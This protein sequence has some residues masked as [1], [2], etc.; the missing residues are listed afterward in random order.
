MPKKRS[1][2]MTNN[3]PRKHV[4]AISLLSGGLDSILAV[5]VVEQQGIT[6]TGLSFVTPFFTATL[7]R[8]AANDLKIPLVI[9]DITA[10]H[11]EMQAPGAPGRQDE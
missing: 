11:F 3:N 6:V 8:K 9:K 5:K 10:E 7:A 2:E 1:I 4:R